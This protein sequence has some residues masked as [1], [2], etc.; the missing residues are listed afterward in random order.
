MSSRMGQYLQVQLFGESHGP[1]IGVTVD[2]LPAGFAPD[3]EALQAFLDRRAAR[4]AIA[5]GRRETDQFRIVSGLGPDGCTTGYALTALFDNADPHSADYA[6]LPDRP[7]PGHADYPATARSGGHDD[8][9]GGGHHSGRLTLAHAFAGGLALQF[10]ARQGVAI[11]AHVYAIGDAQDAGMIDP[12]HPDMKALLACHA[13][14]V[15]TLDEASGETMHQMI[16]EARQQG[17]SLGGVVECV[18][19]GLPTGLGA[20]YFD[21]VESVLAAQ[22]FSIPAVKGVEFGA[23]FAASRMSGSRYNDPYRMEQGQVRTSTNYAGGLL[24]GITSGMPVI[25]RAAF[26]PTP[27]ISLEQQTVSLSKQANDTLAIRGRHDP[28]VCVRAVPVVEAAVALALLDL[29]LEKRASIPM[30]E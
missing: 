13:R 15:P 6:F 24:G 1:A 9:R 19:E 26:R 30:E 18:A 10:L 25:V 28:C 7:R 29:W 23:G 5:T 27:S 17:D 3:L 22:L 4:S 14:P 21:G 11:G 2:G 20:P 12:V 8:L 16:L